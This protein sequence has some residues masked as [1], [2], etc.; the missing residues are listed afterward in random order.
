[1]FA[2][3]FYIIKL[4]VQLNIARFINYMTHSNSLPDILSFIY[5]SVSSTFNSSS[6]SALHVTSTTEIKILLLYGN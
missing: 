5:C 3:F 6:F 2:S 1:M 4:K